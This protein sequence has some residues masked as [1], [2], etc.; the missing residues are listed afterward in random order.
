MD[1]NG[2]AQYAEQVYKATE[3]L[4][5]LLPADTLGWRPA[6]TNNWMTAGQLLHHLTDATGLCINGFITGQWPEMRDMPEGEMLPA[7]DH[8]PAVASVYEALERLGQDRA[9]T[10]KLLA[11]L[12][13]EDFQTRLVA[14]PWNPTPV[15]L[16][17][18]LLGMVEHQINHKAMLF[19]YLKLL[20][21]EVNT[22]HLYGMM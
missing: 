9:L 7:A 13:E 6:D 10:A 14:A 21:V 4:I 11:E 16:W 17:C 19:A 22:G 8:M 2:L 5:K 1:T 12:S 15:P 18:Q 3:G 20:G